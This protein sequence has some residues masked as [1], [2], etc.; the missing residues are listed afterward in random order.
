MRSVCEAWTPLLAHLRH[1]A[2]QLCNGCHG[3]NARAEDL[4]VICGQA[5]VVWVACV[6]VTV[7]EVLVRRLVAA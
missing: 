1:L 2:A 6:A 3:G 4:A 7:T 5:L